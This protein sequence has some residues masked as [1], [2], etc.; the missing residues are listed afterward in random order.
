VGGCLGD[1]ETY[2]AELYAQVRCV[3]H[4]P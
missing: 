2:G 1:A 3:R 4:A